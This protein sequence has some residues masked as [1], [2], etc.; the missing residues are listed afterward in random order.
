MFSSHFHRLLE[1]LQVSNI[2]ICR[3]HEEYGITLPGACVYTIMHGAKSRGDY[4]WRSVTAYRLEQDLPF[5]LTDLL[6]LFSHEKSMIQITDHQRRFDILETTQTAD[7]V[8][9][10]ALIIDQAYE[11]LGA[12][13]PREWP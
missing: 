5:I 8:L 1:T 2:M 6:Q 13:G 4:G 3:Q 9:E 10:H 7:R 12:M 11:L